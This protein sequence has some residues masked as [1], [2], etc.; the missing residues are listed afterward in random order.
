MSSY[1]R[2]GGTCCLNLLVEAI[3]SS[4]SSVITH[5]STL[6]YKLEIYN[7]GKF[8]SFCVIQPSLKADSLSTNQK[9]S[10]VWHHKAHIRY[11]QNT[12]SDPSIIQ[13]SVVYIST[14]FNIILQATFRSFHCSFLNLR[15]KYCILKC[16]FIR[17]KR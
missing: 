14:V 1:Q 13:F 12:A 16:F 4:Q 8:L 5:K 15:P 6:G 11:L 17:M 10:L 3:L 2:F 7:T 9:N